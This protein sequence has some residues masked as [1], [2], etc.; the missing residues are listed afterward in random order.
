MVVTISS[1]LALTICTIQLT[2][3]TSLLC[4]LV[5]LSITE[6]DS[7]NSL[8]KL[9]MAIALGLIVCP[10]ATE[11]RHTEAFFVLVQHISSRFAV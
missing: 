6:S 9:D 10:L 3:V 5:L 8:A 4:G 2:F 11:G 7:P 1:E